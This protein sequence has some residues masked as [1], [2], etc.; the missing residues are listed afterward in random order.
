[1]RVLALRPYLTSRRAGWGRLR[2]SPDLH[3][4]P[5]DSRTLTTCVQWQRRLST[6][7]DL[8]IVFDRAFPF[9]PLSAVV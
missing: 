3:V 6:A 5:R 7:F 8:A 2:R 9:L 1:M 4:D